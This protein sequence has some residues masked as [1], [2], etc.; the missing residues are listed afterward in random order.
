MVCGAELEGTVLG[1]PAVKYGD[2]EGVTGRM[3]A[4][5]GKWM[6]CLFE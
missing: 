2:A 3:L 1:N 4:K 6:R 5:G